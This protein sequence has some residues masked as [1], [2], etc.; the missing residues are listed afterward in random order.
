MPPTSSARP[1]TYFRNTIT[2]EINAAIAEVQREENSAR[3]Q[4]VTFSAA[5]FD[6]GGFI[7]GFG[8]MATGPYT[9]FVHARLGERV[10]SPA[11]SASYGPALD[12]MNAGSYSRAPQRMVAAL[13]PA[14][15][16][17]PITVIAW[18]GDSVD[19][20]LRNGG[21]QKLQSALNGNASSYSGVA[22][23]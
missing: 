11:A 14:P 16:N 6:S 19:R 15:S 20:W 3:N 1:R 13:P 21:A 8:S 22:L 23:G 17:S 18:D 2:P 5:Q 10:M 4:K 7:S 9:G 12:A